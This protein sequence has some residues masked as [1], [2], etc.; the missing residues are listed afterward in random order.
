[1][2]K[3]EILY[4]AADLKNIIHDPNVARLVINKDKIISSNIIEG[5]E[6]NTESIKD[7]VRIRLIVKEGKIIIKPVHLCFGVTAENAVQNIEINTEIK[8]GAS[9]SLL[10]HCVF[11]TAKDVLHKMNAKILLREKAKYSY[12]EKHIHSPGGGVRVIPKTKVILEKEAKFKTEFELVKG[13]VGLID[14]DIESKCG[15]DSVMEMMAR[16][17]GTDDDRIIIRET[18]YL[19]GNNSKGVLTSRVAVR[20]NAKAEIFNKLIASGNY[21]RGHVDC[22]EIIKDNG[23]ASAVPIV[24]VKN[25]TAHITHEASIGSVDKKQLETLMSRGLDEDEATE[26]IIQGLLN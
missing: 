12:F 24:E 8:K 11:P 2:L 16:I 14:M 20:D 5:I 4:E 21:S 23:Q 7:G 25:A 17:S 3:E 9:I 26:L 1:M 10:A 15:P 6:I 13:R 22:K 18:G 19:N